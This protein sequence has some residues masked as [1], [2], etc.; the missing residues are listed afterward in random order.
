MPDST[1]IKTNKI[2]LIERKDF[3]RQENIS[4]HINH[5]YENEE[6]NNIPEIHSL[7]SL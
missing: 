7:N 6:N 4:A 5:T 1:H 3:D 2:T